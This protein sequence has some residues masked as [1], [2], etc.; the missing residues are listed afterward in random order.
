MQMLA[1]GLAQRC[2]EK[3]RARQGCTRKEIQGI[4]AI[5]EK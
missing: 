2:K 3:I 1:F 5:K 4:K